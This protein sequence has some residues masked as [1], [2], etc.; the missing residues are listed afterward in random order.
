MLFAALLLNAALLRLLGWHYHLA[1]TPLSLASALIVT[2]IFL[3]GVLFLS[4]GGF[5]QNILEVFGPRVIWVYHHLLVPVWAAAWFAAVSVTG[6]GCLESAMLSRGPDAGRTVLIALAWVGLVAPVA[7]LGLAQIAHTAVFLVKVSL[8]VIV[9]LALSSAAHVPDTLSWLQ[10]GTPPLFPLEVPL[11]LWLTPPLLVAAP[12][13]TQCRDHQFRIM[14]AGIALPLA[15]AVLC[16][17]I[18]M[19]GAA[20]LQEGFGKIP[21]YLQYAFARPRQLGWLKVLLLT[22]T[23]LTAARFAANRLAAA[24]GLPT[25][26]PGGFGVTTVLVLLTLVLRGTPH[27]YDAWQ[28]AAI[29]FAPLAAVAAG[30][31]VAGRGSAIRFP[32]RWVLLAWIAGIVVTVWPV[33]TSSGDARVLAGAATSFLL[34][35]ANAAGAVRFRDT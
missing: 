28:Y 15:V 3:S 19:A 1:A 30:V 5:D 22:F 12:F 7:S 32:S 4:A 2:T 21:E 17:I 35:Y 27:I 20:G 18:T 6:I 13:L 16:A 24:M 8:A 31:H 25:G 10:P 14:A 26:W 9:G 34:S 33:A 23:T 29:P 11:L